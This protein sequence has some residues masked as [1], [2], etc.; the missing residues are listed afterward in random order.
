MKTFNRLT[1]NVPSY[2]SELPAATIRRDGRMDFSKS[3]CELVTLISGQH[4][5]LLSDQG[6]LYLKKTVD[7]AGF[8]INNNSTSRARIS[9]KGLFEAL[10]NLTGFGN[11]SQIQYRITES[12]RD[13]I[14]G[15]L[16]FELTVIRL[17]DMNKK[18][19]HNAK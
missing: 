18:E 8:I 11:L 4:V 9:C 2:N 19:V 17:L 7:E 5:E 16:L 12:S 15:F 14:G 6:K 1:L 13:P 10:E 3:A